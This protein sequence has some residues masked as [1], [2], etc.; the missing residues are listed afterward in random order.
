M[1]KRKVQEVMSFDNFLINEWIRKLLKEE[2]KRNPQFLIEGEPDYIIE[3]DL[4]DDDLDD[5]EKIGEWREPNPNYKTIQYFADESGF[6]KTKIERCQRNDDYIDLKNKNEVSKLRKLL[7]A[8]GKNDSIV[9]PKDGEHFSEEGLRY[10]LYKKRLELK[11]NTTEYA[12]Y[13]KK[14]EEEWQFY[15][16]NQ[17]QIENNKAKVGELVEA[18]EIAKLEEVV[19]PQLKA[20]NERYRK[21]MEEYVEAEIDY[22]KVKKVYKDFLEKHRYVIGTYELEHYSDF[23]GKIE[24]GQDSF[25]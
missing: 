13:T 7:I 23:L 12:Q 20:L 1:K 19:R 14:E 11:M 6:S 8:L 21:A 5:D 4:D 2:R 9:R 18:K 15:C 10:Y 3:D 16:E 17:I 25:W 22:L 24:W